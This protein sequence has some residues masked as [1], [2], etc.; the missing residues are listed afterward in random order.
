MD[1]HNGLLY[2]NSTFPEPV[3]IPSMEKDALYDVIVVGGGMSGSLTAL[4]LVEKGWKV[5]LLD[6]RMPGSGSTMANTGL[7]QYSNDIMLHELID[8]IDERDAVRF[9]E[10]CF[11]AMGQLRGVASELPI[12]PDFIV[13]PSICYAS[14]DSHVEKLQR[15]YETL[16]K[17]GF[18]CDYWNEE[19]VTEKLGFSKP[20]ALVTYEDA[21]VNPYKFVQGIV[22]HLIDKGVSIFPYTDVRD[23]HE[24][25]SLL[26][27]KTSAGEF[28]TEKIVWTTGYETLPVGHRIGADINR[29]YAMV[30]NVI[31]QGVKTSGNK[32]IW[33]EGTLIWETARPYLY[34]RQTAEGRIL[35]GGLDEDKAEAPAS[36]KVIAEHA[37]KL[38]IELKKLFPQ[39]DTVVEFAYGATFGESIDN[40]P[41]I[42]KHPTKEGHYYLLGYGGNG[43]VYSM[44]G[45][46]MIA[47][48]MEN[49]FHPDAD[50]VQLERKYGIK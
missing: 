42:G 29:S 9:Y 23:V 48:L 44:L 19:Q 47:E 32:D 3:E 7:L 25:N 31:N 33:H 12:D 5:A 49:G 15:E 18:P 11:E 22:K 24:E 27:V 45:S 34:I 4:A 50:L 43:T 13:R 41:F 21:E 2:W 17:F 36:E 39:I 14:E 30:T 8:Q 16:K 40:L 35:I 46:K 1:I 6:K 26:H 20:A 37:E 28:V 38:R 10:L